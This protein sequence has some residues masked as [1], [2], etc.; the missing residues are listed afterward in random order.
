MSDMLGKQGVI[1]AIKGA[2]WPSWGISM[3]IIRRREW[4]SNEREATEWNGEGLKKICLPNKKS[5]KCSCE[6]KDGYI[7]LQTSLY[8]TEL[9][10]GKSV[11]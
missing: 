5:S 8:Y 6:I 11:K 4:M 7:P 3:L 1:T 2:N 10:Q 9:N